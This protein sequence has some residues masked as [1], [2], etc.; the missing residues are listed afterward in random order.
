M[1]RATRRPLFTFAEPT[2]NHGE[3]MAAVVGTRNPWESRCKRMIRIDAAVRERE[4]AASR[5]ARRGDGDEEMWMDRQAVKIQKEI[6]DL[7]LE[8]LAKNRKRI[9]RMG[10]MLSNLRAGQVVQQFK[11]NWAVCRKVEWEREIGA[12]R[13]AARLANE[14]SLE[15]DRLLTMASMAKVQRKA[16]ARRTLQLRRAA[17]IAMLTVR[18][19]L[20]REMGVKGRQQKF[21]ELM[22]HWRAKAAESKV[23][24]RAGR[25]LKMKI[26]AWKR[27]M[28]AR[29]EMA[30]TRERGR[31][32]WRTSKEEIAPSALCMTKKRLRLRRSRREERVR[33]RRLR[34]G[35]AEMWEHL[36]K[37]WR[38]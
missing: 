24:V 30:K 6:E 31:R 38:R 34:R 28:L 8:V 25:E 12:A 33:L 22:K 20:V 5:A 23:L 4:R 7:H 13:E 15:Q 1:R 37:S 2:A 27:R 3:E 21:A 10:E 9:V 18:T 17:V 36:V 32:M 14:V 16:A 35:P 29:R 26:F 11:A 19:R